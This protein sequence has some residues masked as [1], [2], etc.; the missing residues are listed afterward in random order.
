MTTLTDFLPVGSLDYHPRKI[1]VSRTK[2]DSV[3]NG[4]RFVR[5]PSRRT[6]AAALARPLR[7]LTG[8]IALLGFALGSLALA[9]ILWMLHV[10]ETVVVHP[11][12]ALPEGTVVEA[13]PPP[14]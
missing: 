3:G 4:C 13:V 11:G 10:S 9:G 12:G 8:V 14:K 2:L 1:P 6:H 5:S 7:S